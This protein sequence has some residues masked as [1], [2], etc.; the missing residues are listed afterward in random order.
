M[1]GMMSSMTNLPCGKPRGSP[2][3]DRALEMN[4]NQPEDVAKVWQIC[5]PQLHLNQGFF[6]SSWQP[7]ES[8]GSISF[9]SRPLNMHLTRRK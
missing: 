9:L 6:L 3:R 7:L 4:A 2:A 1:V 8:P 5:Q